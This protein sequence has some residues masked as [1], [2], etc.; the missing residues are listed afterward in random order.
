MLD[1]RK[2]I[3]KLAFIYF[4]IVLL[5]LI[6]CS[7]TKPIV[8]EKPVVV[9]QLELRDTMIVLRDTVIVKDSLWYGEVTDSL[10]KVLG[11]LKVHFNKKIAELRLN[12][13]KDTIIIKDTIEVNNPAN[14][15]IPVVVNT[16]SWWEQ[17]ILFGT[18]G[19]ILSLLIAMRVK[20]GKII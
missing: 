9:T 16:L 6:G 14:S 7:S 2:L 11:D 8:V 1:Q 4:L 17:T 20:R 12:E 5:F 18:L 15:I 13:R 10:G 3:S 19:A